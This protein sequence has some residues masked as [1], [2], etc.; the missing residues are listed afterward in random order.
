MRNTRFAPLAALLL[1]V[2]VVGAARAQDP[3]TAARKPVAA[4]HETKASLRAEA[5]VREADARKTA[6]A[7]VPNGKVTKHELEREDGKLI[8]SYDIEVKGRPGIEEVHVDAITGQMIKH[9]HEDAKMEAKEKKA[10]HRERK[11][12]MKEDK[13]EAKAAKAEVKDSKAAVKKP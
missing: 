5:K 6:L 8:Y 12:E 7:E 4:K 11:S 2:G 1:T 9:E 3:K 10:E 13:A